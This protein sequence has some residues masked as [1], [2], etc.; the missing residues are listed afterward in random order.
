MK[1]RIIF[2]I[3]IIILIVITNLGCT[4]N[5]GGGVGDD[6][7]GVKIKNKLSTKIEVSISVSEGSEKGTGTIKAGEDGIWVLTVKSDGSHKVAVIGYIS[8]EILYAKEKYVSNG[9]TVTFTIE[10]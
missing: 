7:V 5:G 10:D 3:C 2:G 9:N 6:E 1:Q 8:G 4:D